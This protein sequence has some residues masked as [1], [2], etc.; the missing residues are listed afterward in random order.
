M[1]FCFVKIHQT[2]LRGINV[3]PYKIMNINIKYEKLKNTRKEI[4][5]H[6]EAIETYEMATR[7]YVEKIS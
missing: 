7:T 2:Y 4:K 6:I 3:F 5:K 1:Q